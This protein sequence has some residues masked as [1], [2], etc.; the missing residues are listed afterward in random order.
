MASSFYW[1]W[2]TYKLLSS[3]SINDVYNNLAGNPSV[4]TATT[5]HFDGQTVHASVPP[6]GVHVLCL[7]ADTP[8]FWLIV[9]VSGDG[10]SADAQSLRNQVTGNIGILAAD[11]TIFEEA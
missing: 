6:F 7:P 8:Y 10:S 9:A 3:H 1:A 5:A 11:G 2:S 4:F